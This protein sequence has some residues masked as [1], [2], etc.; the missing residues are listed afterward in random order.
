MYFLPH[1]HHKEDYKI[2]IDDDDIDEF[3]PSITTPLIDVSEEFR[4][5][6]R[7]VLTLNDDVNYPPESA[8]E[9]INLYIYLKQKIHEFS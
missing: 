3:Y 5:F 8:E 2:N 9:A 4:E 7:D 6:A 1:L